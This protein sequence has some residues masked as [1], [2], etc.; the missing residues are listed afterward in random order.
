MKTA[1]SLDFSLR[2]QKLKTEKSSAKR[3]MS[4]S[5]EKKDLK[6]FPQN[7]YLQ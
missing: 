7:E 1:Y 6:K 5:C 2:M 3:K 4:A